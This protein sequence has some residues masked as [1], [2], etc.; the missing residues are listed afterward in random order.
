MSE[1]IKQFGQATVI[2]FNSPFETDLPAKSEI[3]RILG[4][5][6]VKSYGRKGQFNKDITDLLHAHDVSVNAEDPRYRFV[7]NASCTHAFIT[8]NFV[9]FNAFAGLTYGAQLVAGFNLSG[10]S[11]DVLDLLLEHRQDLYKVISERAHWRERATAHRERMIH[12]GYSGPAASCTDLELFGELGHENGT[13]A[14]YRVRQDIAD[15]VTQHTW[16]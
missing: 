11:M 16:A 5:G 7:T 13:A 12:L 8:N 2:L 9:K 6:Q 14:L 1:I 10:S 15:W 4:S 3:R